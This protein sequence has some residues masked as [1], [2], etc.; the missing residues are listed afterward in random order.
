MIFGLN[1]Q[2]HYFI[3]IIWYSFPNL[4]Y[5][6]K[7]K[8]SGKNKSKVRNN[9]LKKNRWPKKSDSKTIMFIMIVCT[10]HLAKG[11]K[12]SN[13]NNTQKEKQMSERAGM[14]REW[15]KNTAKTGFSN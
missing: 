4:N 14:G 6:S 2:T 1:I 12:R 10:V 15:K 9:N 3:G 13:K 5:I 8:T 11:I 7:E